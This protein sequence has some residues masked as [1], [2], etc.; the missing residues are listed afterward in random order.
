MDAAS[1]VLSL[2]SMVE[3]M[4]CLMIWC[5]YVQC[6]IFILMHCSNDVAEQIEY[7]I[8]T[9]EIYSLCN[10]AS[11]GFCNGV[12]SSEIRLT[13]QVIVLLYHLCYRLIHHHV[14]MRLN[15]VS[16]LETHFLMMTL[17]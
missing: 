12:C 6:F 9:G 11:G 16:M 14:P 10:T 8:V 15:N 1:T 2:N 4:K 5:Q 3:G 13:N 17:V 7:A